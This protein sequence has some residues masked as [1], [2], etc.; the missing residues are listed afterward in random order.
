VQQVNEIYHE[1]I[2]SFWGKVASVLFFGASLLFAILFFYQW[3]YG[4]IGDKPTPDWFFIIMFFVFLTIA[5]L[6]TNFNSLTISATTSGI[7]AG[8]GRFRYHILWED[9]GYGIRFGRRNEGS[10]LVYNT[11]G[12]PVVL[13]EVKNGKYRYFGFSNKHS[14]KVMELVERYKK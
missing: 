10:V 8:Y 3:T 6:S 4:P 12:S 7:T 2:A 11:M 13:I 14:D 9:G 5:L 1:K